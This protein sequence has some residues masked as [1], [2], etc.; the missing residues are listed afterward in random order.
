M[1]RPRDE[2]KRKRMSEMD[3][4]GVS[5]SEIAKAFNVKPPRVTQLLGAKRKYK[6][7]VDVVQVKDGEITVE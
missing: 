6:K 5:R 4:A 7:N 3:A 2:E 1:S